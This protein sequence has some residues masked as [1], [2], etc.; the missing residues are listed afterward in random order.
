[1]LSLALVIV[2]L[3]LLLITPII[4]A[5]RVRALQRET[6]ERSRARVLLNDLEAAAIA[7]VLIAERLGGKNAPDT[8]VERT[9]QAT[10]N[11]VA[12][13]E[14]ELDTLLASST[15]ARTELEEIQAIDRSWRLA[16]RNASAGSD[17]M[18]PA[19]DPLLAFNAAES[20]D[21][22]LTR[23]LDSTR[24]EA[25]RL[26]EINLWSA[27]VLTPIALL[28]VLA[29]FR[30]GKRSREL[31]RH[32][33]Q[34]RAA[35]A[36]S[37]EARAGLVR[38]ITHDLK[39]PLGAAV[40]YA[41]LLL[42]G[43][44]GPPLLPDHATTLRRIRRLLRQSIDSIATLVRVADDGGLT[45][46]QLRFEP[47][48]LTALAREAMDDYR[49][50]AAERSLTFE[51]PIGDATAPIVTDVR[52]VQ[53]I[54]GNLLSNAVKYTTQGGK[55]VVRVLGP[56]D[57]TS[58]HARVEVRDSGPGIPAALRTRVF[59][60]FFRADGI[61]SDAKGN[62]VGL[63]ISRRLARQ[64]GGDLT[65]TDASEGGAMFV[66]DLPVAAPERRRS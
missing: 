32:L 33:E 19:I 24:A 14:R 10:S 54:L 59:E 49:A 23:Q 63:S 3:A 25:R 9:S 16:R 36:D 8:L 61:P 62:G 35:L 55:V 5:W 20:L 13:D 6:D 51:G 15:Y 34:E 21:D 7:Q 29:V 38:G 47:Y 65:V 52:H 60:E 50:A 41:D 37:I 2:A 27:A 18:H 26:Q 44:A 53:H 4:V 43:M 1:M 64:L 57:G 46:L 39:N 56:H 28:S 31:A 22:R 11:E 17:T 66:F 45:E 58:P 40:G 30:A 12:R 42:E 48:D